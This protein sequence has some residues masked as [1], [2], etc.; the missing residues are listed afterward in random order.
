M[1]KPV[2][3]PRAASMLIEVRHSPIHGRGV[4][5]TRRIKSGKRI[6]EY[7]GEH[8]TPQEAD[9]RYDDDSVDRPHILLFTVDEK[10]VIDGARGGNEAQ[11][12]N[13]SCEPNCEAVNDGGRIF[14][15]AIRDIE[16]GEELTYDY[17]LE[18][19]GRY[20][21]EW[22]ERYRCNCGTPACR[23][24]MLAPRKKTAKKPKAI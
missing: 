13:H 8:I 21:S 1:D 9:R 14:V 18:R 16:Q 3:L 22:K 10:T 17:N 12:I 5:A 15:E 19:G 4:F 24:T 2:T 20:R 11:F 23:G 6:I 7:I